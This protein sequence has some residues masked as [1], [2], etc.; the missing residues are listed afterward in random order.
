[1]RPVRGGSYL[2]QR[3]AHGF[4]I[5]GEHDIETDAYSCLIAAVGIHLMAQPSG[6]YQY[7]AGR[8][9]HDDLIGILR[10]QFR[11][12]R[13]DDGR[14]RSRVV[15]VNGIGALFRLDIVNAAQKMVG[16][17]VLSMG[18]KGRIQVGPTSRYLEIS[19][20]K[21]QEIEDRPNRI[22]HI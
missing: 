9:R 14:L 16:V 2:P 7:R 4:A 11:Y 6:E 22:V 1:M 15:K 20:T 8:H 12:R 13:F 17:D 3:L 18:G 21:F 5:V 19:F 10:V